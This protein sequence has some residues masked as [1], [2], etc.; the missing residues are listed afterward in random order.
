MLK[1]LERTYIAVFRRYP[2]LFRMAL[3]VV[4]AE[5]MFA[6]VNNYALSFYV[7]RDLGLPGRVLGIVIST[8]LI[9]E[10]LLKFPA[11]HLSDRYGRRHFATLGLAVCVGTP[12]AVCGLPTAALALS[13][14]LLYAVLLPLRV[15]DGAGSAAVWPP[16]FASVPDHVPREER[17][18]AMSVMNTAYIVGLGLGPALAGMAMKVVRVAGH[19]HWAGKAPFALA[20]VFALAGAAVA[21]TLPAQRTHE[22]D[23]EG[24]SSSALPPLRVIGVVIAV[25]FSN[26]FAIATLGPYLAPY[27]S[28]IGHIDPS[29]VGLLMLLLVLPAAALGMPIGHLTDRWEKRRVVQASLCVTALGLWI[30]PLAP[31]LLLMGL[32]SLLVLFGFM[33]GLPAWLALIADLAPQGGSGKVMGMM[34]TAQGAGAALGPYVGGMMWDRD[35]SHQHLFFLAAGMLTV[36]SFIALA[37]IRR[38]PTAAR[39]VEAETPARSRRN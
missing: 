24:G 17:G 31:S 3:V 29:D 36:S 8:F 21:W 6:V 18:I 30:V 5:V 32:S 7:L 39:P 20:A 10:M 4:L 15:V 9:T 25:T 13:P 12:L 26:M 16:L 22:E 27:L 19:P 28:Q 35:P 23:E 34:A 33:F 2:M 1:L 38:P 37:F 11:G 14:A